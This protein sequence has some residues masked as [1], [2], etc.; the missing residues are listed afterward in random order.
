[1]AQYTTVYGDFINRLNEVKLLRS[2]AAK[3]QRRA[4]FLR[5]GNEINAYCR[6]A[7]VLLSSHI[8]AYVKE[9]GEHALD[10]IYSKAVCR[11]KLERKFFY[12][13]SRGSVDGLSSAIDPEKIAEGVFSFMSSD[14]AHWVQHGA[15]NQPISSDGF[16]RGF[17]NP[18]PEKVR[19]YLARFGYADFKKDFDTNLTRDAN[20]LRAGVDLIVNTRNDIAHGDESASKTPGEVEKMISD[21]VLF[22]RMTDKLFGDWCKKTVCTIR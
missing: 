7:I 4:D 22:C 1:M 16:N 11:S 18:K 5:H 14:S 12:Y 19:K 13:A 20:R 3:L 17:S 8:E 2:K 6:G 21:A 10:A 9:L 15:F